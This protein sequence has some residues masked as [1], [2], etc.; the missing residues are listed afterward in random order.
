VDGI[1]LTVAALRRVQ[2][3]VMIVPFTWEHTNLA[4][5]QVGDDVNLEYDMVG[6]YVARAAEL[7]G[8]RQR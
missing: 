3:D 7:A 6:K 5:R 4:A 8:L 2:F 1:S